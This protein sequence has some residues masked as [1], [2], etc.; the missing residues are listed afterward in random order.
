M[1]PIIA[2]DVDETLLDLRALDPIGQQPDIEGGDLQE[3]VAQIIQRDR[4]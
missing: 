1:Q 2:F 3:V 4:P